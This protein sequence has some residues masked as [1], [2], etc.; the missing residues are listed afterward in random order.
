MIPQ[1]P[2]TYLQ[3]GCDNL[4]NDETS[5]DVQVMEEEFGKLFPNYNAEQLEVYNAV[6][7]SVDKGQGV[8]FVYGS[9]GC[10]KAYVWKTLIYKLRSQ[11]KIVLPV[12]SSGIAATLMPGG[13]TAHSH[14]KI[15]IVLYEDSSCSISHNSDIAELIKRTSLIIWYEALMQH[16]YAFECLD[17]SLRDIMKSVSKERALLPFGGITVLLGGDFRQILPV[18]SLDDRADIVSACITRSRLWHAA[19][20]FILKQNMRLNQGNTE[21]ERQNLKFFADWVLKIGDGKVHHP[22]GDLETYEENDIVIPTKFCDVQVQNTVE[23]MIKRTY[24][25]FSE[26]YQ[27]PKYLS[28]RAILTPTNQTIGHLNSAIVDTIPSE[29]YMYYNIDKAEDFG[30]TSSD[31]DFAF[32]PEYL[33]SFNI[34]GLPPH[35]LKLKVG[36]AVMLMHN[37]NQTLGLCNE[38]RM[39]VTKCLKHCVQCEVIYGA[40]V[41]TKH[42]IPRMELC[43]SESKLPFKLLQKQ[44]PLQICY[45][46]TINKA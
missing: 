17:R 4:I 3:T 42:F 5:Y 38:T 10:G 7:D 12:A 43:P 37:L 34:P 41:G 29:I 15:T 45:S 18:I 20:I 9:G 26:N 19:T 8:F 22:E 2:A 28:E 44:M 36:V 31:L 16:M 33:N 23:N 11:G 24:P 21:E 1:P 35:E 27:N 40:F 13:R 30:G 6:M 32:P 39:M 25:N 14:F 46:M